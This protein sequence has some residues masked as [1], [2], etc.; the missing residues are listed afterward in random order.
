VRVR[1]ESRSKAVP[2][3]YKDPPRH[4][5]AINSFEHDHNII[6]QSEHGVLRLDR[7]VK[8]LYSYQDELRDMKAHAEVQLKTKA[9]ENKMKRHGRAEQ[10]VFFSVTLFCYSG[11]YRF[12]LSLL[13]IFII[14]NTPGRVCLAARQMRIPSHPYLLLYNHSSH[15]QP[16]SDNGEQALDGRRRERGGDAGGGQAV[17]SE[18]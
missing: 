6:A 8:R 5:Q 12:V 16:R 14:R 11:L 13:N 4:L 7:I 15:I 18:E 1:I 3:V 2:T 17:Q 10:A 9:H